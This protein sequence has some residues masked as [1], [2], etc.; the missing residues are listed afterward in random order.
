MPRSKM[1]DPR[2]LKACSI[3]RCRADPQL[4]DRGP[5][6]IAI[7]QP[8]P[9]LSDQLPSDPPTQPWNMD[10]SLEPHNGAFTSQ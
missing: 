4:V 7:S 9:V 10:P 3:S 8:M 5:K 2:N 1:V 6:H